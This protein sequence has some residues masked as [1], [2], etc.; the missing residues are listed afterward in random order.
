MKKGLG[1]IGGIK[2]R[3]GG[4]TLEKSILSGKMMKGIEK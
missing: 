1:G 2:D 4:R 3:I